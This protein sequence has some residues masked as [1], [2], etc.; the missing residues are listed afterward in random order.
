MPRQAIEKNNRKLS[1]AVRSGDPDAIAAIYTEDG[2]LL[3]PGRP[4][5]HGRAAI[6]EFWDAL[7]QTGL[8]E[9]SLTTRDLFSH[10][11]LASEVGAYCITILLA[12][13]DPV[14]EQGKYLVVWQQQVDGSWQIAADIW[15]DD[16]DS[17]C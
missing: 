13:A 4:S 10:D 1:D 3:P 11:S 14:R 12:G 5:V 7:L 8:K 6:R 9:V 17:K 15:N 2:Q 16:G